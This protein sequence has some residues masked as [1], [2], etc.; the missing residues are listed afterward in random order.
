MT[1]APTAPTTFLRA[2][3]LPVVWRKAAPIGLAVGLLQAAV[4]QGDH[5]LRHEIDSTIIIKTILSPLI[6]LC[7]AVVSAAA[8]HRGNANTTKTI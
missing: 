1:A 4:N 7:L 6:A 2:L 3:L 8:S 5:W